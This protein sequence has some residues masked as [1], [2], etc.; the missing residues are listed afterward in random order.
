MCLKSGPGVA[1][2]ICLGPGESPGFRRPQKN[3]K[4]CPNFHSSATTPPVFFLFCSACFFVVPF[5][6]FSNARSS[7]LNALKTN[8]K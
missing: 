6:V 4:W 3:A 5:V 2:C 8:R 1:L 7:Q